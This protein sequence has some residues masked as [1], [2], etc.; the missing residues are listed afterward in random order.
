M[1]LHPPPLLKEYLSIHDIFYI[2]K[3]I[4]QHFRR[5]F[6]FPY[7]Q[8]KWNKT[9]SLTLGLLKEFQWIELFEK[10]QTQTLKSQIETTEK[11][12]D[13]MVYELYGLSEEEIGIVENS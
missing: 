11:A 5:E 3:Q 1:L 10:T 6:S 8:S 9:I 7:F 13:K 2:Q 12:I 4:A